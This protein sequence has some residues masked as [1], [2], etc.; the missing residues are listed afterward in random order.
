VKNWIHLLFM[1]LL[2]VIFIAFNQSCSPKKPKAQDDCNFVM[3]NYQQRVSW[4]PGGPLSYTGQITMHLHT[5]VP[6]E[7][8]PAIQRAFNEWNRILG[9]EI[10]VLGGTVNTP[11]TADRDGYNVIY[12]MNQWETSMIRSEQGRTMIYWVEKRI[13]EAD[14][15]INNNIGLSWTDQATHGL[16][17]VESL[18]IH[19]LGHVLGLAHVVRPVPTVMAKTLDSGILRR[20]PQELDVQSVKCEY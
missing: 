19:E 11:D 4:A 12:F 1:T 10:L 15:M 13:F 20:T 14:V 17:D 6:V 8:R 16:I 2:G 7:A 9:R 3:N 5:S 18:F